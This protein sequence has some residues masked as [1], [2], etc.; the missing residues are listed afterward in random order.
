MNGAILGGTTFATIGVL[1]LLASIRTFTSTLYQSLFGVVPN[2]TVGGIALGTFAASLLAL[3]ASWRLGPRRS[4]AF[5][6][7]LLVGGTLL[8]TASRIDVADVVLSGIAVVGG[9]WWLA[10]THSARA[11]SGGSPFVLGLPLALTLDLALRAA[12]RT[13][14]VADLA[15]PLA[16]A[17]TLAGVLVFVGAGLAWSGEE[18]RWTSPGLR[19]AFAL[20]AIP[21]LLLVAETGATDPGQA[22]GASGLDR[23]PQPPGAWYVV[24]AAL[25]LGLT[26]GAVALARQRPPARVAALVAV[27]AGA[28]LFWSH[29]PVLATVGA[30]VLA[31]GVFAGA[32]V[33]AD[34]ASRPSRGP[35]LTVVALTVGW[36]AFV[37]LAF[38]FYA[39]YALPAAVWAASA[40]V[41]LGL[42]AAV[43]LPAPRLGP[44]GIALVGAIALVVPIAALVTSPA[45]QATRE[46]RPAF[47]LM[48]YN[49]HQGFDAGNIP[50]VD[51]IADVIIAE[52]PDVVVLQEVVRGWMIDEQHDVLTVLAERTGMSYVFGP[53]I[54]DVYGNAVL[55]RL[56][57][58]GVRYISYERQPQLRHQP[59]GA[60]LFSVAD[61][62]VIA[63]HLDHIDSRTASAVRQGQVH[64]LLAAW[65]AQ[66]PAVV[67]GDLNAVPGLPELRLLEDA[68]FRD[69]VKDDGADQ[70]TIPAGV[71]DERIDYV[72]GIGV[73]GSGAH[74]V[75]TTASDHRPVVVT[76]ERR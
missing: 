64:S 56:P 11:G 60:I 72:W 45:Q 2:E 57:I 67:A 23:G 29:L 59:R 8:S 26:T 46:G 53:A 70:P 58:S 13:S 71:P 20:V 30:M 51:R 21:A 33:L 65:N 41:L 49:V 27:A 61:V 3:V 18:Q 68:G 24:A 36:V 19:G 9:T 34:T 66:R 48:T 5:S 15:P 37:A 52:D 22:A 28:L 6:G 16:L 54:G 63:T 74:T 17:L 40:L 31:A 76:I 43:P 25:G 42:V 1:F 7:V 44:V 35:V 73:R 50:S 75:A 12:F 4:V 69:L 55:S 10:L 38:L 32:A 62:L 47:R 14:P 39:Y